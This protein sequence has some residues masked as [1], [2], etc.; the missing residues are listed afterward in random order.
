MALGE[1][2]RA[3]QVTVGRGHR[4]AGDL[5]DALVLGMAQ[6]IVGADYW[7]RQRDNAQAHARRLSP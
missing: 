6:P 2:L 5:A 3:S 7:R 4:R 1:R